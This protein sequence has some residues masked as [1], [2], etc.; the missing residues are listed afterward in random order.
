MVP[1]VND[2]KLTGRDDATAWP[3]GPNP[4]GGYQLDGRFG[5]L[6]DHALG[7]F[8]SHAEVT[9]LPSQQLLDDL[10]TFQQILFTNPRVREV[11]EA[12]DAATVPPDGDLR[13]HRE[14]P[15]HH[16]ARLIF[17]RLVL[18]VDTKTL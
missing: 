9:A 5:T 8:I 16:D 17:G 10:A 1:T 3:R 11:A 7:A 14:E 18:T 15:R 6:Q 12:V 13:D 2:V 4:L